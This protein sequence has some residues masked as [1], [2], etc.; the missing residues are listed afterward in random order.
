VGSKGAEEIA[1]AGAGFED[2]AGGVEVLDEAAR[3]PRGCLD[4]IVADVIAIGL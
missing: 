1:V 2:E 3:Q 4:I